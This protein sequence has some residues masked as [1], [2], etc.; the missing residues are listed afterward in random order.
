[1]AVLA[2]LISSLAYSSTLK[3]EATCSP[4]TPVDFQPTTWRYI[5]KELFIFHT[6][7]VI[8]IFFSKKKKLS[9]LEIINPLLFST[10]FPKFFN[11]SYMTTFITS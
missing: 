4:E 5:P 10:I 1:M 9:L 8:I 11:S 7:L 2:M 6:L 3:M